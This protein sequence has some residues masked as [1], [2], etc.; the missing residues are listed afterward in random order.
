VAKT[1][2]IIALITVLLSLISIG[3]LFLAV[4]SAL[5][6]PLGGVIRVVEQT[7]A[8]DF[9][10]R[11]EIRFRDDIGRLSVSINEMAEGLGRA[12]RGIA[13][14][15]DDLSANANRLKEAMNDTLSGTDHQAQQASLIATAAEE[16]SQTVQGIAQSSTTASSSAREAMDAARKGKDVIRQS[17]EKT[18]LAGD[19]TKELSA[20]IEKMNARVLDIGDIISVISGI[21]DQTNLLALNAAIE[22]ARAGEQGRGFAV[23][24]DEVRKLAAKTMQATQEIS[25]T[26]KAVQE[27]SG[28]TGQSMKSALGHV[29]DS[30][31]FM[32]T[33]SESL[34]R[35][36]SSVQKTADEIT[37]IATSIDQQ[38][39]TSEEIA[40]NIEDISQ[41]ASRTQ[42]STEKL[43]TIFDGL[44]SLSQQLK[45][46]V[47][48][49]KL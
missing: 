37:Q 4:R 24:A 1:R 22:A 42:A 35:I 26:I 30:V 31:S 41:I 38:T 14:V 17:V 40:K 9:R 46:T 19:A 27:D 44:N 49:F 12:I 21:A 7:A 16:M 32:T 45:T 8:K 43:R 11:L 33:A 6:A 3:I 36:V 15:T 48:E 13:H 29:T 23:V 28:L 47:D 20:M 39:S 34:D 18:N 25:D 10:S 2:I 5:L